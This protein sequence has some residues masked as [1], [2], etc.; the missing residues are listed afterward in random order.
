MSDRPIRPPAHHCSFCG[1]EES[2]VFHLVVG[3]TVFI[4]DECV[5]L[6]AG[7]I[8]A[9]RD[10]G[11]LRRTNERPRG[12]NAD[13]WHL[14]LSEHLAARADS[15]HGLTFMAVQI[16][17]AIEAAVA[18]SREACAGLHEQIN[19]ASDEERLGGVPGCGA[20]GAVIE[21]RDAIRARD[22]P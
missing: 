19:P 4:C 18:S 1:K 14:F 10:A 20:M 6:A 9:A 12:S 17:N 11:D 2:E 21:Y 22:T 16:A 5:T 3:P 8:Q 13:E 15:P 7:V